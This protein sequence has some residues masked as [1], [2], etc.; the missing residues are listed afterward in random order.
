MQIACGFTACLLCKGYICYFQ[1]MFCSSFSNI[2]CFFI[3]SKSYLNMAT[4]F[5]M[6][7]FC[8][9]KGFYSSKNKNFILIR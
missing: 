4:F 2:S 9:D 6:Y 1:K 7:N 3:S 8:F 5:F